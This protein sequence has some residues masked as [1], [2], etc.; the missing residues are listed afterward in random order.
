MLVWPIVG[1][2]TSCG[3]LARCG[4]AGNVWGTF[5]NPFPHV[6]VG[7][8]VLKMAA[9]SPWMLPNALSAL[10]KETSDHWSKGHLHAVCDWMSMIT[11]SCQFAT[12]LSLEVLGEEKK[13][14][15]TGYT[16]KTCERN[17]SSEGVIAKGQSH[18]LGLRSLGSV[19]WWVIMAGD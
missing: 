5:S 3:K 14:R 15:L 2:S 13:C 8:A 4:R 18:S 16:D 10:G 1:W 7:G 6:R 17:F 9:Q 12:L 11:F 19:V